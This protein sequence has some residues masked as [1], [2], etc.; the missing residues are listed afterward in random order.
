MKRILAAVAT[1]AIL[2]LSL[3][4]QLVKPGGQTSSGGSAGTP[5]TDYPKPSL[6]DTY[7]NIAAATCGSTET[8]RLGFTTNSI[9]TARCSGSAWVW[10]YGGKVA[11][12]LVDGDFAW[13]NQGTSTV[14]V[15]GGSL[16]LTGQTGGSGVNSLRIRKKAAPATPYTVTVAISPALENA[17]ATNGQECGLLFR[18]SSDGKLQTINISQ[19]V[20]GQNARITS[21]H[22]TNETTFSA[23]LYTF[24]VPQPR[25]LRIA[26]NGT[27]RIV[28]RSGDGV[29]FVTAY[30]QT[31]TTFLTADEVGIYANSSNNTSAACS[32][33]SWVQE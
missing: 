27:N 28:S 10:F 4:G 14:T 8:G 29:H 21:S 22:W 23:V 9:Y 33:I 11:V 19:A 1:V 30:S 20:G 13:I 6:Y 12:P 25:Y 31:R 2:T 5:G 18:Q 16:L 24:D 17:H 32:F 3:S 7:A 15:T 26:D